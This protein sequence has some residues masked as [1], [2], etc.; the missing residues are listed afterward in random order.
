MDLKIIE[1]K[2][3]SNFFFSILFSICGSKHIFST[4]FKKIG[5]SFAENKIF[6]KIQDGGHIVKWLLP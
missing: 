6:G 3:C 1:I 4:N 2:I 5:Q